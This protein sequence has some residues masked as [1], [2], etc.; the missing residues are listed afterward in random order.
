MKVAAVLLGPAGIGL[1]GILQNLM[2]TASTIASL[3]FGN[4]GTRQ[5]AQANG[6]GRQVDVDVARRALFWG[7]MV[8]ALIGAGIFWV[9]RGTL[10][11]KVLDDPAL[12]TELGWLA[13]GVALT[14]AAG[15][16]RALLNGMRRIGDLARVSILSSLVATLFGVVAL[17]W[18]GRAGLLVFILAAP[19]AN[20]GIS[21]W[22]VARL[23]RV[24]TPRTP[25]K[26]LAKQWS[27]LAKL[28]FAFMIAA[29][30]TVTGP[31]AGANHGSE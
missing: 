5:I 8:L 27:A 31:V 21:H 22:Y 4:V 15:S 3:G 13:L 28:G 17:L 25:I 9:L 1:I 11:A 23:P 30:T 7:T 26:E 2:A 29:L 10:A 18:W 19:V 14:V 6:Q 12:S 16:Q 24:S 20:F